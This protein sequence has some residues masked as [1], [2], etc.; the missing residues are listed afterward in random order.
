MQG[1]LDTINP[2]DVLLNLHV[3][4]RSG[5]LRFTQSEVKK[6]V[7]FVDGS[8]VFAHSNQKH[9]RL[10][11]TLLRLG[12]I[13]QEEFEEA[14]REVIEKGTRLGLALS[15]KGFMS[16]QEVNSAVHYQLQQIIYSVFDWDSGEYEFIDRERP[17]FED[18][19]IDISTATLI[20]DGIRNITNRAVLTRAYQ[21]NE[22]QILFIAD[23]IPRLPRTDLDYS[24]E[25]ILACIDNHKTILDIRRLSRL[26]DI[27][28]ERAA[29]CLLIS[30]MVYTRAEAAAAKPPGT[31]DK[32]EELRAEIQE[33]WSYATQPMQ[34]DAQKPEPLK[35]MSEKEV[36]TL[37]PA[38][39]QKF[40]NAADE[41][42]LN[43]LP[44]STLGEIERAYEEI[45]AQFHPLYYSQDR[46]LDLKDPLKNILDR[47]TLSRDNLVARARALQP[48]SDAPLDAVSQ[49][50]E[51][52]HVVKSREPGPETP[53]PSAASAPVSAS[54]LD[55]H[56]KL[57]ISVKDLELTTHEI[58]DRLKR[59]PSNTS[60]LRKLGK[61]LYET[62]KPQEGEKHLLKALEI[63]PQNI[64]NHFA[65]AEFYQSI[66]LKIKA[67]KHLNIIL[68]IQPN[69]NR[70]LDLL[71]LK[72]SKKPLYEI[73]KEE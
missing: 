38:T 64:D 32:S 46:F 72:K 3:G 41:E 15:T 68:Q 6:S 31:R 49:P 65:L 11:E 67:F 39:Q 8:I 44:D 9:D 19:M 71:H 69:N 10:G 63:E 56:S 61:K 2:H 66:G 60:L 59:E 18:I 13:T 22:N 43:V 70:A 27:E 40:K 53:K 26:N 45:A 33:R 1:N 7:Y 14:S 50:V 47:L 54:G 37:I 55:L 58:V 16:D 24:E 21:N 36:R 23:G 29:A 73:S 5:I 48:F 25:T 4:K 12:K 28:F 42:V 34:S 35:T 52:P 62:G 20:V 17:V 57:E 30:G 51:M